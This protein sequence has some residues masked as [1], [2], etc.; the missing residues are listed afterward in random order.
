MK[1]QQ[2][3][4]A[5]LFVSITLQEARTLADLLTRIA[6]SIRTQAEILQDYMSKTPKRR[7]KVS[8]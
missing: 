7:K 4:R 6:T 3:Q 5:N 8:P 2:P 1:R